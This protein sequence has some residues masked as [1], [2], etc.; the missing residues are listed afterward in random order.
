MSVSVI[1]GGGT[2]NDAELQWVRVCMHVGQPAS[3]HACA[4]VFVCVYM[5]APVSVRV[6]SCAFA[7][8]CMRADL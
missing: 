6:L 4:C 2:P 7:C 5:Y 3:V 8:V 1:S